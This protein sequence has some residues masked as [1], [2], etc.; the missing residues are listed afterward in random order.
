MDP[1]SLLLGTLGVYIVQEV[2]STSAK[3]GSKKPKFDILELRDLDG[4]SQDTIDI[5]RIITTSDDVSPVGSFK[6]RAHRYPGDIDI[7][8]RI[9]ACCNKETALKSIV[10]KIQDIARQV[11][12]RP[13]IFLGD[14]KAGLDARYKL[15]IGELD[16]G[17][18]I[19]YDSKKIIKDL[20]DLRSANL[21]TEKEYENLQKLVKSKPTIDDFEELY[22]ALRKYYV[23]RWTVPEILEGQKLLRD[24]SKITLAEALSQDSIV[25]IDLWAKIDGRYN[26]VTNYFLIIQ[27]DEEGNETVLNQKLGDRLDSL[28]HDI[29]KYSSREHRNSLKLAKRLWNRAI[30]LKD[31][32]ALKKLYPLFGSEINSLNQVA[33]ESEVLRGMLK[34]LENPPFRDIMNQ[35]D[36]FKRRINDASFEPEIDTDPFYN[37]I[38]QITGQYKKYGDDI[39][40]DFV[41]NN[42]DKLEKLL[43]GAIEPFA[44]SFLEMIGMNI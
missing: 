32:K 1:V 20:T 23:V 40:R 44:E 25:K 24:G 39:D 17:K 8:E 36:G 30:F 11:D 27:L 33:G 34:K 42:L 12:E 3:K 37:L 35:I 29:E 19:N 21:L 5:I 38:D 9:K 31:E 7:M 43:K 18:I 13:D 16:N 26:E 22:D 2:T 6:Y 15:D 28:K 4:L 41:I 14:F 10:V